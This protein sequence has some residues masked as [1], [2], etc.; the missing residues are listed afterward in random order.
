M[1]SDETSLLLRIRGD[2]S[3]G[4]AAVSE[5][6]QA[7]NGLR[8]SATNDLKAI[9]TAST[10][11]LGSIVQA[12]G[13]LNTNLPIVGQTVSNLSASFNT[14]TTATQGS[15]ASI[16]G[17]AGAVVVAVAA[18]GSLA[19]AA[20]GAVQG[21]AGLARE[22]AEFQGKLFD[23]SQQTGVSVE[24]LSALEVIARTTG[25]SIE[26]LVA[27]LG[28]FQKNLEESLDTNSKAAE[29]FRRLGVE[30]TNTEDT[31]RATLQSLAKMPEGFRQTA[32]A[33]ELFGRGG[34]SVLAVLKE[35]NGDIDATIEKL[36]GLG[37]VTT[38]QARKADQFNDQ[39]VLLQVALRGLGSEAIP[40]V[41]DA[42]VKLQ[43]TIDENKGAV[44]FLKAAIGFLAG[45]LSLQLETAVKTGESVWKSH[46]TEVNLVVE[47][48]QIL[49]NA[50]RGTVAEIPKITLPTPGGESGLELLRFLKQ[51]GVPLTEKQDFSKIKGLFKEDPTKGL[52][53][54]QARAARSL[55][56]Q[57]SALEERTR[58]HRERL[59]RERELD[60][61]SI[62]AWE[63]ESEALADEHRKSQEK[64][65]DQEL[66]N[67]RR[68]IKD[69]EDL[70]LAE[71]D[72][73]QRRTKLANDTARE[74]ERIDDEAQRRRDRSAL[75]L[76]R[77]L[78][79]IRESEREGELQRIEAALDRQEI[80]ESEAITRRLALEK[81]AQEDR[82]ILL[83]AEMESETTSLE[84][85]T[86]IINEK[87][88]L[89][90]KYTDDTKRLIQERNE[91]REREIANQAPG[92]QGIPAPGGKI[93]SSEQIDLL[94]KL[95]RA[96]KDLS[97]ALDRLGEIM[98]RVFGIG[99]KQGQ[100]FA[101][102]LKD[103]FRDFAFGVGDLVH[104]W[105]LLGETGPAAMRRLTASVLAGLAA[106]AA[107]KA[108]FELAEGFAAL[109]FNPAAAAAHFKAAALFGAVAGVAAIAGRGIA[110]DLFQSKPNSGGGGSGSP[111]PLN[112]VVEQGRNQ[113]ESPLT[114]HVDIKHEEG[115]IVRTWADD[116]G[117]G[118]ITR[119]TFDRDGR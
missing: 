62:D 111:R 116:F 96:I 51:F 80:T 87:I 31:F 69:R 70:L 59:E 66:A 41:S 114:I 53:E 52:S 46:R 101:N 73:Q 21:I 68:F 106:Q 20:V 92:A 24:T 90:Q 67:A 44:D 82:L 107:V 84:R 33:L 18:L 60:L 98:A 8:V 55:A 109:F 64:I 28:I 47:A 71:T 23:L 40:H 104:Q 118:G 58:V 77:Q 50:I 108:I 3:G 32:L 14:L 39:L 75:N 37:L 88:R 43:K 112:T 36:R 115:V 119:Q 29:A 57:Q 16:A 12:S 54:A 100:E 17:V 49:R 72:I 79:A 74:L 63:T 30:V 13:V 95:P 5:T 45:S 113:R 81:Q 85:K 78:A 1:A 76:E 61:K 56:L 26:S 4:K 94:G 42:L 27:S 2:A 91:A 93:L 34:K 22:T 38:E 19:S 10:S 35:T 86:E 6:R 15:K 97:D 9:Q 25:S 117:N 103:A 48:Y 11:S 102:L 110:G 89:E 65:L 99:A 7:L 83:N 105:V